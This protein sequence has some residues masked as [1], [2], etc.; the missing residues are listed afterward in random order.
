MSPRRLERPLRSRLARA[1]RLLAVSGLLLVPALAATE[2]KIART[3]GAPAFLE[4]K[5][6]GVSIDAL[7]VLRLADR[8]ELVTA[9]DEPFLLAAAPHP[10]GW[11]VGTGNS[12]RVFLV[13]RQPAAGEARV[14]QLLEA[15]EEEIF[16]VLATDDGTVYAGSSPDGK[17]YRIAPDGEVF[18]V[19]SPGE[20]YIW[21]LARDEQGRLLVGTGNNGKL[22]RVTEQD[23]SADAPAAGDTSSSVVE[24]FYD[25]ADPH[26]RALLYAP[27][28]A[29]RGTGV[30]YVGTAGEGRVLRLDP[31]GRAVSLYDADQPEITAFALGPDGDLFAAA[32]ASEASLVSLAPA[33]PLAAAGSPGSGAASSDDSDGGDQPTVQVS[34]GAGAAGSRPAGYSG[35]RSLVLRIR[36]NGSAES[37]GQLRRETVY[38]L[39]H[40]DRLWVATGQ[41]GK[42]YS[43]RGSDL[44]LEQDLD[45]RQLMALL[46]GAGSAPTVAAT[47]A[48]ALYAPSA[49]PAESG[50]Y[51]SDVLDARHG[52]R[53]GTLHWEGAV[54]AGGSISFDA[55]SGYSA[56]PDETWAEWT[57]V[58]SAPGGELSGSLSLDAVPM[59]RYVQWR[60]R[61]T[62]GAAERSSPEL[63][64]VELSFLQQN[65]RPE[66]TDLEVLDPGEV[67]VAANFN[68]SNQ[69]FEALRPNRDG[70]FTRIGDPT[71]DGRTKKLWKLGYRTLRWKAED[72]NGDELHYRV[73]VRP[74]DGERW[75]V[76]EE[77]LEED[78]IGFDA[79]VLPD[80]RYRFR[81]EAS[82]LPSNRDGEELVAER[83]TGSIVVDHSPPRIVSVSTA[84][85]GL[86][87]LLV[88][89]ED[90]HLP[91]RDLEYSVDTGAWRSAEPVDG[92]VDARRETVRLEVPADAA[93]VL[94]RLVDG[95][96]NQRTVDVRAE[97]R[98]LAGGDGR[99]R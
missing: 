83:V 8:L 73:S 95:A 49:Q 29:G 26:I 28:G 47:D 34:E 21:A 5:A 55:R 94:L 97:Q 41:S 42:L 64:A 17:L 20:T 52:A 24:E 53:F 76:I 7:G 19:F 98:R 18:V 91:L 86:P 3:T 9:V 35:P 56:T 15:E 2:V 57:A 61:L 66:I 39:Q 89:V 65:R 33:T 60:A 93:L 67:L 71:S 79:T 77:D 50:A 14:E 38:A 84:A 13:R 30:L 70:V 63:R 88:T 11:V 4:G 32:V 90:A 78:Q 85:G 58:G 46:P 82:D 54:P 51:T 81:L 25:A 87:G 72:P 48:A 12:G 6:D 31:S 69:A 74:E 45:S 37:V 80:G 10:E 62:A 44:V 59:G 27:P 75:F 68:P 96:F 92:L 40:R 1:A 99:A 16:A 22:F 36:P 43:L 23:P